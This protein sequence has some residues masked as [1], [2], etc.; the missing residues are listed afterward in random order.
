MRMMYEDNEGALFIDEVATMNLSKSYSFDDIGEII[1][2]LFVESTDMNENETL[3]IFNPDDYEEVNMDEE[4]APQ[5]EPD[6]DGWTV[7]K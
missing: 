4:E 7:V 3:I 1:E 5:N 2:G 6:E